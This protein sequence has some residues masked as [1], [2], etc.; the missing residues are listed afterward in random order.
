MSHDRRELHERA[1]RLV[2]DR[3]GG[4]PAPP[5]AAG[6]HVGSD[7]H[8]RIRVT[9]RS[10]ASKHLSWY[11]VRNVERHEFDYLALIEFE[12]DGRVAG[13][14]GMAWAQI[15]GFSHSVIRPARG[16]SITKLAARGPWTRWA[17]RL[18]L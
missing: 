7:T 17:Q 12:A 10:R 8:G 9:A 15:Q 4:T 1:K 6:W 18:P 13:A 11:H 3:L 16:G 14:W 5:G 2:A